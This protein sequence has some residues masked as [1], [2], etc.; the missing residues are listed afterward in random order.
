MESHRE[1]KKNELLLYAS[2]MNLTDMVSLRSQTQMYDSTNKKLKNIKLLCRNRDQNS[3]ADPWT[4]Q[5][6][7]SQ[8]LPTVVENQGMTFD[9]QKLYQ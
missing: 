9:S 1:V 3:T 5:R 7:Q 4:M 2:R 8:P 6:L